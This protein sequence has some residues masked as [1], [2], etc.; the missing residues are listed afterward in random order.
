MGAMKLRRRQFLHLSAA[1]AAFAVAAPTARAQNY[2]ARPVRI[3]VGFS[4]GGTT[5]IVARLIGQWLSERL[6]QQFVIENRP[7]ANTNLALEA[8]VRAAADG[9]TLG[10]LGPSNV[11]NTALSRQS[12]F[13]LNRDLALIAGLNK[14]P[15]VLEVHPGVPVNSVPEF[16]SY[17]KAN[18][19]RISMA[20]YG[21]A[22][23]SH[24]AG[25]LFKIVAGVDLVH[26][27]YRG[28]AP[29]LIDL[30]GGQVQAAFDNLPASIEHIRTGKLRALAVTTASRSDAVP[31]IPSLAEFLPGYEASAFIGVGA[32]KSTP[33]EIVMKLNEEI[34]AGLA[35]PKIKARLAELGSTPLVLSP[36]ELSKLMDNEIEKW[37]KVIREAKIKAE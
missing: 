1:A 35:D 7:G 10:T 37:A 25:E 34:N 24:V 16:I 8:V 18:Q 6:G 9:Y 14:S 30:L 3:F 17:A 22:S 33:A 21:T 28:S 29:M 26:V 19:G 12:N 2:P 4:A 15:L 32:P 5:D 13:D 11:L 27:P 23:I 20:S 31:Q 36:T